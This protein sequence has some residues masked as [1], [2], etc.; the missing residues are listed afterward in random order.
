MDLKLVEE[1]DCTIGEDRAGVKK[2]GSNVGPINCDFLRRW[3]GIIFLQESEESE[4][5]D[6]LSI[7]QSRCTNKTICGVPVNIFPSEVF[8]FPCDL[9][10]SK[11]S[12]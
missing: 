10:T 9:T 5:Y 11:T 7:W 6:E 2:N 12:F 8:N 1:S 3:N 4:S